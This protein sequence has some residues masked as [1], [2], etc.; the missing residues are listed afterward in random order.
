MR[1]AHLGGIF[2]EDRSADV[3][4]AEVLAV[5]PE[6]IEMGVAPAEGKLKCIVKISN[7]LVGAN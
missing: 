5:A 4:N 1:Q 2:V 3:V 7:G 6:R